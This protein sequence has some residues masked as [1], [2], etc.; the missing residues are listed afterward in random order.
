MLTPYESTPIYS[1]GGV[2]FWVKWGIRPLLGQE[3]CQNHKNKKQQLKLKFIW[4]QQYSTLLAMAILRC[5]PV[6]R[7]LERDSFGS[8]DSR[9]LSW[10]LPKAM[11]V[12]RFGPSSVESKQL[13]LI[14]PQ[15]KSDLSEPKQAPVLFFFSKVLAGDYF[16]ADC[17][18][19]PQAG[20]LR[21]G[22]QG[23]GPAAGM[24][25]R[26]LGTKRCSP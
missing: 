10:L 2:H 13:P 26:D 4:A 1:Y 3:P 25:T 18:F 9:A 17:H 7:C 23:W 5:W 6:P 12:E 19:L 21:K 20:D 14:F 24:L 15:W 22:R 11:S 8:L 16:R